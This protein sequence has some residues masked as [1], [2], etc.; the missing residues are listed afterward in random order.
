M[1][2]EQTLGIVRHVLTFVGGVVVMKGLAT[3]SM[4]QEIIGT[5]LTLVGSIWSVVAKQKVEQ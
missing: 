5:A 2:K 4:V 1:K 3:D